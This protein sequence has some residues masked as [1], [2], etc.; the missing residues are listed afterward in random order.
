[1]FYNISGQEKSAKKA[2]S[3]KRKNREHKNTYIVNIDGM[4]DKLYMFT[5]KK[6]VSLR[7]VKKNGVE[8]SPFG[9]V[10]TISVPASLVEQIIKFYNINKR[11]LQY[12]QVATIVEY[13]GKGKNKDE[14]VALLASNGS[15]YPSNTDELIAAQQQM[16]HDSRRDFA[17][18]LK[19]R[20]NII[21][22]NSQIVY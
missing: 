4:A 19:L 1:M 8:I 11:T 15:T 2:F 18:Q 10:S 21:L 7:I 5:D 22:A 17:Y 20:K 16:N 13:M 9:D 6:E 3:A 12:K 14:R